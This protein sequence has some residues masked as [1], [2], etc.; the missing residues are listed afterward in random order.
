MPSG[1]YPRKPH[2]EETRAKISAAKR[3]HKHSEEAKAKMS[4]AQRGRKLTPEHRAKISASNKGR[5]VSDETRAKIS[6]AWTP[7]RKLAASQIPQS[8]F[9][10]KRFGTSK[11]FYRAGYLILTGQRHPLA[12]GGALA[13]HRK[14][15]YDAIG[16]GPHECHWGCGKLLQWGGTDGIHV[17]HVDGDRANNSRENLVVSCGACNC[18]RAFDGNPGEWNA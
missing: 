8:R 10:T 5:K 12:I 2:S 11:G 14:V 15:L 7:E 13:E 9:G 18:L 4:A 6:A 17:D 16:P 3:G 1:V